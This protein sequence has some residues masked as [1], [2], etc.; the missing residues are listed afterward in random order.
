MFTATLNILLF[1]LPT[2]IKYLSELFLDKHI[3]LDHPIPY[4]DPSYHHDQ[5]PYV[6]PHNPPRDG[7]RSSRNGKLQPTEFS[8]THMGK[9]VDFQRQQVD[10]V[11]NSIKGGDDL[12][13]T[14]P[15]PSIKTKLYP[16]QRKAITFLQQREVEPSA[17]KAA[18]AASISAAPS[19][20]STTDDVS[21]N[22]D[23]EKKAKKL[24]KK[25][26]KELLK[27]GFNSLWKPVT[28]GTSQRITGWQNIVSEEVHKGREK[29]LEGRGAIL[30][31]DVSDTVPFP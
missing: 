24:I 27:K 5:P 13:E 19:P 29:P 25:Q 17:V 3:Y 21:S 9:A 16:H 26:E 30:A 12:P 22:G 10:Q 7:F 1:T 4:Y 23:D 8:A 2:N 31:D 28:S 20:A 15:G 18:I 11:F 14:D 6:N